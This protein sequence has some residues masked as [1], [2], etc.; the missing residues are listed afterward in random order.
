MPVPDENIARP[1]MSRR[2]WRNS[3]WEGNPFRDPHRYAARIDQLVG[4]RQ[5]NG[6]LVLGERIFHQVG[7]KASHDGDDEP[8]PAVT[9]SSAAVEVQAAQQPACGLTAEPALRSA[10][11]HPDG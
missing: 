2:P 5:S 10:Q 1:G 6:N 7:L 8:L 9:S 4:H 11:S 3:R